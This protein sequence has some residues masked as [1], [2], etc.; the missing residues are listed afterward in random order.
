MEIEPSRTAHVDQPNR[1]R[2]YPAR[3]LGN[4][5]IQ[6]PSPGTGAPRRFGWPRSKR[7]RPMYPRTQR[8]FGRGGEDDEDTTNMFVAGGEGRPN[9]NAGTYRSHLFP[10]GSHRG[11]PGRPVDHRLA[12]GGTQ[13]GAGQE[14]ASRETVMS[15]F[16]SPYGDLPPTGQA[17]IAL[18]VKDPHEHHWF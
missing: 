11:T 12:A 15:T 18:D 6:H 10:C 14:P 7:P 3:R 4:G 2:A 13:A 9:I 8:G 5:R 1:I 16:G 17:A